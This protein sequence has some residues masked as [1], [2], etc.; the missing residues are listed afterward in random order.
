MDLRDYCYA[1]TAGD[2]LVLPTN[3]RVQSSAAARVTESVCSRR[4]GDGGTGDA[5]ANGAG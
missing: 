1:G 4:A 3:A 5:P 2:D